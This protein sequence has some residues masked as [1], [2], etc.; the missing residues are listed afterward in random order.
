MPPGRRS[1][2]AQSKPPS[3]PRRTLKKT[4]EK[5]LWLEGVF[6]GV[7][8]PD[9]VDVSGTAEAGVAVVDM[10]G[11]ELSEVV[12]LDVGEALGVLV[13]EAVVAS[14][15][16]IEVNP[17]AFAPVPIATALWASACTRSPIATPCVPRTR[18]ESPIAIP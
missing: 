12:G 3:Q 5:K 1:I 17:V 13:P 4:L 10:E 2:P 14:P 7:P 11:V 15:I 18:H 9:G 16:D 8:L 6:V